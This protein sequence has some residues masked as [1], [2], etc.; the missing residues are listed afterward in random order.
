MIIKMHEALGYTT[1]YTA[2]KEQKVPLKTAYKL[3]KLSKAVEEQQNFYQ[4]KFREI[5]QDYAKLN[6]FGEPEL[7]EDGM[8]VLLRDG[9]EEECQKAI[10]ELQNLE[11]DLPDVNL[12]SEELGN[13]ELTLL[14]MN[15]ILPFLAD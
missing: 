9:T 14:E 12:T 13:L 8:S 7:T 4:D 11:I 2:A 3:S 6:E 10:E 1:F 5:I 15:G